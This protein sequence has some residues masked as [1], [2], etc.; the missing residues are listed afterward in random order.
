MSPP[1]DI[2]EELACPVIFTIPLSVHTANASSLRLNP[3]GGRE[4]TGSCIV[5]DEN[6]TN[7][8]IIHTS[9]AKIYMHI[10]GIL[11]MHS[12]HSRYTLCIQI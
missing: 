2:R 8:Y 4:S 9:M 3:F 5:F 1:P 7:D 6:M 11:H 10:Y 12:T